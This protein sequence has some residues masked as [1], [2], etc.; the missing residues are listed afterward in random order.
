MKKLLVVAGFVGLLFAMLAMAASAG[1]SGSN[2]VLGT[3]T[4]VT[5]CSAQ[6]NAL[7]KFPGLRKYAKE[8][9]VGNGFVPGVHKA[10]QLK[11]PA[12]PCLG[13]VPRKH[14]HFFTKTGAFG[15]RDWTGGQ[16][17]D[18]HYTLKGANRIVIRK[19]F[20]SVTFRYAVTGKTIRF[21]PLIT[22]TCSTFR[23][24]WSL[25]MAIPGTLWTRR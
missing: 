12:H 23:C 2:P 14:S 16:V 13:A 4:A 10:S 7:M 3:W 9:V 11:D 1:S 22:K 6:Y 8:M 18:G 21:T 15:S 24:A 20:P 5:T 17:D 25:S 19:E